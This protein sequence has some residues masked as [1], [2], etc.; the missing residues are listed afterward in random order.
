MNLKYSVLMFG[1]LLIMGC[2]SKVTLATTEVYPVRWFPGFAM[3]GLLLKEKTPVGNQ[4]DIKALLNEPWYMPFELINLQTKEVFS[5]DRCSQILPTITQL[6]T[7][8]PYEFPPFIYL[9]AMC[10]AAESIIKARPAQYSFLSNFKLDADFSRHAPKNLALVISVS[11]WKRI[12]QNTKI[13]SWADVET[14]KFVSKKD[15][16]QAKYDLTGA[17]QE[18]SLIARGDFNYDNIEDILLYVKAHVVDGSYV[19]YRLFWLTKT[20]ENSSL[21]LIREYPVSD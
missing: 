2:A 10:A 21:T 1:V 16:H 7:D 20:D 4:Q 3:A 11:E 17:Y 5:A 13:V 18:V 14:V 9:T 12:L 8:K 15:E 19:S 6:E